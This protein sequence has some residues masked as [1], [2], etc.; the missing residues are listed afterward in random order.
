MGPNQDIDALETLRTAAALHALSEGSRRALAAIA[1]VLDVAAGEVVFRRGQPAEAF[2][3]IVSGSFDL[4]AGEV[5]HPDSYL[6]TRYPGDSLGGATFLPASIYG[7]TARAATDA[8]LLRMDREGIERVTA[9]DA[10]AREHLT[11]FASRRLPSTHLARAPLFKGLSP[12][13]LEQLDRTASIVQLPAG[14]VLMAQGD[15][16]D[17]M[18]MVID[19]RLRAEITHADGTVAAGTQMGRGAVIGEMAILTGRTRSATVRAVRDSDLVR[20]GRAEIQRLLQHSPEFVTELMKIMV[21][22][23]EA[24]NTA[25]AKSDAVRIVALL[26][27][28]ADFPEGFT[29]NFEAAL[30]GAVG[31]AQLVDAAFADAR[32]GSGFAEVTQ[33]DARNPRMVHWIDDLEATHGHLVLECD[34][35]DTPWTR[36]C[37]READKV[38]VVADATAD[39]APSHLE[40]AL[41]ERIHAKAQL[42]LVHPADTVMPSGTSRWL[43][44]RDVERHHHVRAGSDADLAR[45]ARYLTGRALGVALSGGG[46]RGFAHLGVLRALEEAGHPVDFV[47]G[48]SMGSVVGGLVAM[49]L[50]ATTVL[51]RT[52]DA[53]RDL[54]A[55]RDWTLPIT[56]L[57]SARRM[58]RMLQGLFGE[59]EIEDLWLPY[60]CVSANF[61]RAELAVHQT[62]SLWLWVRASS[63]VP[64][65]E[66][67]V[68]DEGSYYADGGILNNLPG[69]IM[70]PL[71]NGIVVA[72]NASPVVDLK[73]APGRSTTLSG[74][75]LLGSR[76]RRK[77]LEHKV[78]SIFQVMSRTIILASVRNT[79][80]VRAGA[81]L[82]LHPPT[83]HIDPFSSDVQEIANIGYEFAKE[84]LKNWQPPHTDR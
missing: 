26:P 27:A 20:I 48:A 72:V 21:A 19:G 4:L 42:V 82:Y 79:A 59:V 75:S 74:W 11:R 67:P 32:L 23:I 63:S 78:P 29:A 55:A 38:L 80:T 28:G 7:A 41:I 24:A 17:S 9:A 40:R 14:E 31:S 77:K 53:F 13:V 10:D 60:F 46:A 12:A 16:A 18:Y 51:T 68:V 50:D 34:P 35:G 2:Y 56:S 25:P 62:G 57:M 84:E 22:R 70:R 58:V 73:A 1:R 71:C 8:V 6:S 3:L 33:Q 37:L 45:V 43:A 39:P 54:G 65:I 64:G 49:G 5:D 81:D 76:M 69:D 66:P 36:R 44:A 52:R 61:T 15:P 30:K 83:D 47:G